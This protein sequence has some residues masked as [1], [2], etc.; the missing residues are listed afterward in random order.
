MIPLVSGRV[1]CQAVSDGLVR[2]DC[3]DDSGRFWAALLAQSLLVRTLPDA[4]GGCP[5][6]IMAELIGVLGRVQARVKA[7]ALDEPVMNCDLSRH[8][9]CSY[10]LV[11]GVN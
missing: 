11:V 3:P 6:Y 1:C 2:R 7:A 10:L 5:L 8:S 4:Q 9:W